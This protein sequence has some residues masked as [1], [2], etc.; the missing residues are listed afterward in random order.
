[1]TENTDSTARRAY[2]KPFVRNLDVMDTEG[3]SYFNHV[4]ASLFGDR[5]GPITTGP[6]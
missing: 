3:K 1:M 6:S 4:E 5:L 2:V